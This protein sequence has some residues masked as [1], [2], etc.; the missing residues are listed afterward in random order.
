MANQAEEEKSVKRLTQKQRQWIQLYMDIDD[1]KFFGNAT[2]CALATYYPEFVIKDEYKDYSEE[3]LK[4]YNSAK[5]M[6]WENLTKL[7]IEIKDLMD[8]AGLSDV[9]ITQKLRENLAATKLYG[10][11]AVEHPDYGARNKAVELVLRVKGKLKDKLEL[12]D[13]DGTISQ[14][15]K[16]IANMLQEVFKQNHD[17]NTTDNIPPS[18]EPIQG[19]EG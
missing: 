14:P 18:K 8:E 11:E 9:F 5:T 19:Q 15:M 1:P 10:K 3:E 17:K 7:D 6:G 16:D 13:P 2:K 4:T 12:T